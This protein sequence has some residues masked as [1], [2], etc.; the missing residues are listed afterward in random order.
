MSL[1]AITEED[2]SFYTSEHNGIPTVDR[3]Q[4]INEKYSFTGQ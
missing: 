3:V 2:L 4:L 1:I